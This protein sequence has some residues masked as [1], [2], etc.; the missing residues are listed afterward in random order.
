VSALSGVVGRIAVPSRAA[1]RALGAVRVHRPSPKVQRRALIAAAVLAAVTSLYMFWFR[2]SSFV[3]VERVTVTGLETKDAAKLRQALT[4]SARSMTTLHVRQDKLMDAVSGYPVVRELKVTSDFP[5]ALRIQV[6]QHVPAAIAL[7][8]GLR[9]PVAGDGTLLRGVPVQ[10][11]LPTI[12]VKGALPG[13]RLRDPG[14]LREAHV[15]G[16]APAELRGRLDRVTDDPD[17]GLSVQMRDGP[18]LIFGDATQVRAKWAAA[19]RVL[20]DPSAAGATYLD[21]R[22]PG[23]VAAGGL[24]PV[25]EESPDGDAQTNPQPQGEN[26]S[27]LNP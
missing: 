21:L 18:E 27:T 14:D 11:S 4:L 9:I 6:I 10:G 3:S 2:D 25:A 12:H 22:I 20:A 16:G 7:S 19:A 23:R 8:H 13:E 24:D 5:H 26:T 1:V 15:L 17:Q